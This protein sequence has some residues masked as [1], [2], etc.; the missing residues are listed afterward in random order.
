MKNKLIIVALFSIIQILVQA[1]RTKSSDFVSGDGVVT[2]FF[3]SAMLTCRVSQTELRF[4]SRIKSSN[5]CS[6]SLKP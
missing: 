3:S 5:A 4:C 2:A 1:V 6:G